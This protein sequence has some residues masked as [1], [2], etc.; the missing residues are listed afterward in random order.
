IRLRYGRSAAY[1]ILIFFTNGLA[2]VGALLLF[3]RSLEWLKME[4]GARKLL[5]AAVACGTLVL[6]YSTTTDVHGLDADSFRWILLFLAWRNAG[7]A[8]TMDAVVGPRGFSLAASMEHDMVLF[9]GAFALL[10][11]IR[12]QPVANLLYFWLRSLVTL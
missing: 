9:Y 12:R 4:A 3:N 1:A 6:P 10:L 2:S 8:A 5:T 11:L 7:C